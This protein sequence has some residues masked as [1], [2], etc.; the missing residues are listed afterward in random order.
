MSQ[1]YRDVWRPQPPCDIWRDGG[2]GGVIVEKQRRDDDDSRAR[3]SIGRRKDFEKS[4]A[5]ARDLLARA[6]L[7]A[8]VAA[9]AAAAAVPL[10][11]H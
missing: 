10:S 4:R 8:V 5:C 7:Q 6:V 1:W 9:V 11:N 3:L 2:W